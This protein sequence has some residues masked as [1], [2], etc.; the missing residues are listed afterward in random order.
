MLLGGAQRIDVAVELAMDPEIES[1][2][3]QARS[4][5]LDRGGAETADSLNGKRSRL[6]DDRTVRAVGFRSRT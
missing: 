5:D 3:I 1:Q 6:A 4:P 2:P